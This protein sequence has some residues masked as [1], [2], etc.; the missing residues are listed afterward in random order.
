VKYGPTAA[1]ADRE[2]FFNIP[3]RMS[4]AQ[5]E[6][7]LQTVRPPGPLAD[8]DMFCPPGRAVCALYDPDGFIAGLQIA[9]S[10]THEDYPFSNF[11]HTYITSRPFLIGVGRDHFRPLATILKQTFRFFYFHK[12]SNFKYL[13]CVNNCRLVMNVSCDVRDRTKE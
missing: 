4:G 11:I 9:V 13:Y 12:K 3:R 2:Y 5:A 7:W 6:G 8:L 10:V 1:Q